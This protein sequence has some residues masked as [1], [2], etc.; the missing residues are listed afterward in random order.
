VKLSFST[1]SIKQ[2][3][4]GIMVWPKADSVIG[5][6][7]E[8][9]GEFAEGENRV[10]ARYLKA[11][12]VSVDIGAN[13]GTCTLSM[14]RAVGA[15]GQVLAFEPQPMVAH[16]LATS[17]VLNEISNV[18]VLNLAVSQRTF[19]ARMN[20]NYAGD[21][22]NFGATALSTE[23]D[24]V[25]AVALDDLKFER[26]SFVKIDVEGHEWDVFQGAEQ[27]IRSC[28][29]VVYFEAKR[30]PGTVS[31]TEFVLQHGYRCYWHFAHFAHFFR[32]DNFFGNTD[33]VFPNRG[34]MNILA[35]PREQRQPDDLPE[36]KVADEDW[37]AVYADFFGTRGLK[38]P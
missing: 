15:N 24:L 9:Y 17:L 29:P 27:T 2:C 13:V 4:H 7:L 12:D 33:N 20:F 22:V 11:G 8:K 5:N 18:R 37:R 25:P 14:S 6:A 28:R 31:S 21:E 16:C 32:T 3:R 23:G 35:V 38:L 30:L 1:F 19:I 34:D 10:M 36:I 26:L